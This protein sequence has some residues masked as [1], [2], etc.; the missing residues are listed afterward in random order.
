MGSGDRTPVRAALAGAVGLVALAS[1]A[2]APPPLVGPAMV[3]ADQ[4]LASEAGAEA[5]A[6]GVVQPSS[7]GLGGGGFAVG[8]LGTTAF[9]L[10]FREVAPASATADMYRTADGGVDRDASLK[11]ARAVAVPGEARGLAALVRTHGKLPLSAVAAPAI[12]LASR[13]FPVGLHLA[14]ALE[15][16]DFPAIRSMF[17]VG[18]ALA[19]R[20]T[21][22]KRPELAKAL[23]GW[24]R[25]GGDVLSTGDGARRVSAATGG[26]VSVADLE[27]LHPKVREPLVGHFHGYTITTMPPPSSGGVAVLEALHVLEGYDLVSL[28]HDS[29]DY[30]HLLA[31][32]LKHVFADRANLLGD[33]DFVEVP[34]DRLLSEE[35]AAE[36]QRAIWPGRTFPPEH[37]GELLAPPKDAGTQHISAVDRSGGGVALTTTINMA[38]GSGQVVDGLGVILN[39]EMD[40]FS[41]APGVPNGFGLVGAEANAIA[42]GKRPLSSMSPTVVTDADGRVVLVVGA[43]GG[44]TIITGTLQVLL[45][46]LVFGMDAEEADAAPRIHHQWL[47]N[48]LWVEPGV[49]DDVL[50]ALRARGHEVVVREGFTAVQVLTVAPDHR[51]EGASDP[52]K[53]GAPAAP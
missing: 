48:Q 17:S 49:P 13:G 34:V 19:T 47:P 50:R 40:D 18:G 51:V 38:F 14:E 9:A 16:T 26:A 45:N 30:L 11:G 12:Q 6:A 8:R 46:V 53:G 27:Q 3:A 37:Y 33:P 32:V 5:L 1:L 42:P 15:R 7:S 31:E 10:D 52:R 41:A 36:I 2:V 29:S 44:S 23:R 28:G 20:G 43:S 24:V 25:T 4:Q 35:R 39:D 22:V 21:V